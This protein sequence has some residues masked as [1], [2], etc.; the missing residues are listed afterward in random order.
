MQSTTRKPQ[1]ARSAESYQ[2]MLDA[3]EDVLSDK[4]FDDATINE[5]VMRAGLTIGAFYARFHDKDSLLREL[6]ARMNAEFVMLVDES[7]S[8]ERW[9]GLT[10]EETMNLHH[11]ALVKVYQRR[12]PIAR[13]LVL[14]SHTD[15]SLKSRLDKLN[16]ANLPRVARHI[17]QRTRIQH[18]HPER[19]VRFALLSVRSICREVVLFREGWPGSKRPS[20]KEIADDLTRLFLGYLGVSAKAR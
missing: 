1:Q 5:I 20:A 15:P 12:R 4:S 19:A 13:A 17:L 10:L 6:E 14:R 2:K 11:L 3:A 9:A 7:L 8:P 18:P 16:Q